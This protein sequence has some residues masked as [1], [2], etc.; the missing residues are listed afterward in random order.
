MYKLIIYDW[1]AA[2]DAEEYHGGSR[3]YVWKRIQYPNLPDAK[4]EA[5]FQVEERSA[6]GA[7]I[8]DLSGKQVFS[9]GLTL[10]QN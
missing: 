5:H 4:A 7:K 10:E 3:Y 6:V 8:I 1:D 9:L 2:P